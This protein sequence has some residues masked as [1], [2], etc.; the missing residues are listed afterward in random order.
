MLYMLTIPMPSLTSSY[1]WVITYTSGRI[2]LAVCPKEGSSSNLCVYEGKKHTC[3]WHAVLDDIIII[4]LAMPMM[5]S[6]TLD[7]CGMH[8]HNAAEAIISQTVWI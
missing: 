8:S 3:M 5:S 4:S 6:C 7:V 1:R 2:F